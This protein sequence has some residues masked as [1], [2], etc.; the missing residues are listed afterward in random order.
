MELF[1]LKG[2]IFF[3][4]KATGAYIWTHSFAHYFLINWVFFSIMSWTK[5]LKNQIKNHSG[6]YI[7]PELTSIEQKC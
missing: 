6:V 7:I 1:F 4:Q 3:K 2:V 5:W